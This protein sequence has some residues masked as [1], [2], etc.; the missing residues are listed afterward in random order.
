MLKKFLWVPAINFTESFVDN[1]FR[2][3]VEPE[4]GSVV[5]CDLAFGYAEHSGIYIGGNQIVHL[6]KYGEIETVSP[7]SFIDGTTAISIYVS[8]YDTYAI[9]CKSTA[10]RAKNMIGT[11]RNYNVIFD[12]CHQFSSGCL[13]GDF[14]NSDSFLWMLK[15][16]ANDKLQANSWRVWDI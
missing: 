6:N 4:V 2:D 8:C 5:Y 1:V 15:H 10:Q 12:N 9:G 13:T 16:T 11:D 7:S 14:D 3:K